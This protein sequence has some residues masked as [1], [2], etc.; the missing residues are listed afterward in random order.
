MDGINIKKKIK[1]FNLDLQGPIIVLPANLDNARSK[2]ELGYS[3]SE[4]G[5]IKFFRKKG[6]ESTLNEDIKTNTQLSAE[7]GLLNV[8]HILV[9]YADDFTIGLIIAFLVDLAKGKFGKSKNVK[10][11]IYEENEDQK[12]LVD[13]D[14]SQ[15]GL[16]K[17]IDKLKNK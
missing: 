3:F 17:V 4:L 9:S 7:L 8:F 1:E 6:I 5:A 11:K 16:E 2:E 12:L 10:V 14:G 13:Y 15:K